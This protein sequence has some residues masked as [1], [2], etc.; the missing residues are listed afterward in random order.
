MFG[1]S[2]NIMVSTCGVEF[3]CWVLLKVGINL[4]CCTRCALELVQKKLPCPICR[5]HIGEAGVIRLHDVWGVLHVTHGPFSEFIDYAAHKML[6]VEIKQRARTR[7]YLSLKS[8]CIIMML[9]RVYSWS[10]FVMI[11]P[12][13]VFCD[14]KEAC[15]AWASAIWCGHCAT[16]YGS[17]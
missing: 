16:E 4:V 14:S 12:D 5:E 7:T 2:G 1:V 9:I 10:R 8:C 13:V 11:M 15:S 6:V 3:T 17:Q